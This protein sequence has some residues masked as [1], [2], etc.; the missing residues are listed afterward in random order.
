MPLKYLLFFSW[1]FIPIISCKKNNS[2]PQPVPFLTGK[3]WTLDTIT[4]NL[5]AT[6]N[7]LTAE[8]KDSYNAALSW[9][10]GAQLFFNEDGSVNS[11]GGNRGFG[12]TRCK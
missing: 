1:L 3:T 8:E 12:Y 6:Y 7:S 11:G 5:P 2:A 9:H 4:I 10:T